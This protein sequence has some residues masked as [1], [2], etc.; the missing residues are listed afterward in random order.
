M[1]GVADLGRRLQELHVRTT[2]TP[3]FNPVFQLG[4]E[5][6]RRIEGGKLSL[7]DVATLVAE[8]Q[9]S[10]NELAAGDVLTTDDVLADLPYWGADYDQERHVPR[11]GWFKKW[12]V[13]QHTSSGSLP[14]VVS[15][16]V[17]MNRMN[18]KS[19]LNKAWGPVDGVH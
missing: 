10:L 15:G 7:D 19:P 16:R 13:W 4:L 11:T 2:E 17:D 12:D 1:T 14:G 9:R 6:S 8:L 3:L 5:L 18:L